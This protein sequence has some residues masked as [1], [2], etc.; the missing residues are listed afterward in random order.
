MLEAK[1]RDTEQCLAF[2]SRGEIK[3]RIQ[4][5]T[6]W[7]NVSGDDG[8]YIANVDVCAADLHECP[9]DATC[10]RTGMSL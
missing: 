5:K 7:V 6:A 2:N 8:L 3:T 4:P 1:C 9:L 10:L